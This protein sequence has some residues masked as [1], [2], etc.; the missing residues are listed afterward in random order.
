[1]WV[2]ILKVLINNWKSDL[3]KKFKE[4][5]DFKTNIII[6]IKLNISRNFSSYNFQRAWIDLVTKEF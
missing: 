4:P 2:D 3:R 1:M 5:R 6:S